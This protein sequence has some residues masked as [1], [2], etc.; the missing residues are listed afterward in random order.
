[1][2][3]CR[4]RRAP[5]G[6]PLGIPL[7]RRFAE[8]DSYDVPMTPTF[9]SSESPKTEFLISLY[10]ESTVVLILSMYKKNGERTWEPK[11]VLCLS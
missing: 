10:S 5:D 11:R 1:M 9:R 8:E 2:R 7:G 4:V 3:R 6:L